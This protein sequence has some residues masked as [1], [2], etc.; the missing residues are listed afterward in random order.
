MS[1]N[2]TSTLATTGLAELATRIN[3]AHGSTFQLADNLVRTARDCGEALLAAKQQVPHGKFGE[4]L[5]ENCPKLGRR[6]AQ[7]YLRLHREWPAIER[8][9]EGAIPSIDRALALIA[10]SIP[11]ANSTTHLKEDWFDDDAVP[12][13]IAND[14]STSAV[15]AGTGDEVDPDSVRI[16]LPN[17]GERLLAHVD[18]YNTVEI[19][20]SVDDTFFI[21]RF[22][23][24][25]ETDLVEVDYSR[26]H[27]PAFMVADQILGLSSLNADD[28]A[29]LEWRSEPQ[30]PLPDRY[31]PLHDGETSWA[32]PN[33]NTAIYSPPKL[34]L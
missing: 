14:R 27:V 31:H 33:P 26:K 18:S 9:A 2:S 22:C 29:G 11:K 19:L 10:T 4:W 30:E 5:D 7:K 3:V 16:P 25:G 17:V 6:Q 34:S 1:M 13:V 24:A 21:T 32:G 8:A 28:I 12:I 23:V 15:G 20:R